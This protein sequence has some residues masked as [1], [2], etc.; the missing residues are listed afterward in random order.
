LHASVEVCLESAL[1]SSLSIYNF[2]NFNGFY[3]GKGEHLQFGKNKLQ[4][5]MTIQQESTFTVM[6]GCQS[7]SYD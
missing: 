6:Q 7:L 5:K 4:Q 2:K 3:D 1:N